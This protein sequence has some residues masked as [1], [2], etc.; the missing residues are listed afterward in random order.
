MATKRWILPKSGKRFEPIIKEAA[1]RYGVPF[2]LL[3]RLLYQESRFRDDIITGAI[4][5]VAGAVGIAQFMPQTAA[6]LGL[7]DPTDPEQAIPAA[8]K[9]LRMEYDR[10]GTWAK[11]LAAYNW[12]GTNLAKWIANTRDRWH[13]ALA[14]TNPKTGKPYNLETYRYVADIAKDIGLPIV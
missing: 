10:F 7:T 4:K 9:L 14:E 1:A 6:A 13:A 2:E 3:A 8:A 5:S 12:G 11:A